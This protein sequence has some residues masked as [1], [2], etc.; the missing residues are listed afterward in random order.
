MIHRDIKPENLW[1]DRHG[2]VKVAELGL[3]NTPELAE[4]AEAIRTGK[5]LPQNTSGNTRPPSRAR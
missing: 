2:L 1:L 4:T 5:A 3:I